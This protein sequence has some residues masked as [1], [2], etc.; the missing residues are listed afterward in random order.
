VIANGTECEPYLTSD[1][2]LMVE[3]TGDIVE[4][5]CIAMRASGAARGIVGLDRNKVYLLPALKQAVAERGRGMDIRLNVTAAKY[6]QGSE[7]ILVSTVTGRE[8]QSGTSPE[9]SGCIVLNIATLAAMVEAFRDGLPLIERALT[10]S[11]AACLDPKNLIVPIGAVAS[12]IVAGASIRLTDEGRT[13]IVFGGP[14][15]GSEAPDLGM[16]VQ[17]DCAGFLF[18]SRRE[19]ARRDEGSCIRCGRCM[20]A[21]PCRISPALMYAALAV[22]DLEEAEHIGLAD[23]IECGA[24]AYACPARIGLVRIFRE[25]KER[26]LATLPKE[27]AHG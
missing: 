6:P 11:G 2:R 5:L 9:D 14:M 19:A 3:R 1:E 13:R 16:P 26:V 23:C 15:R 4:G 12:D 8:L 18:L 10:V 22:G 7:R 21:C 17:K 25:G 20:R 27:S 24:C